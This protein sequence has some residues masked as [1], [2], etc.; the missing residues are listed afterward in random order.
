[1]TI[2][3]IGVGVAGVAAAAISA[4]SAGSAASGAADAQ[5]AAAAAGIAEQR[6]QFDAIQKLMQ[7]YVD[8]GTGALTGQQDLLGL[9]GNAA[10][11]KGINAIKTGSLYNELNQQGQTAILQNASATGGLRGGNTQGAL[12]QFSP[13][14][15]Q[16][17]INQQYQN[18][19]GL[20]TMGENAA[21]GVGAAGQNTGNQI[22]ALLQQQGAAQAGGILGQAKATQQFMG[23]AMKGIGMI[24]GAF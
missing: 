2:A 11:Q 17:L 4:G 1:M 16:T 10:Q 7:P 15:L 6:R 8:S 3:A 20:S 18:L 9:N 12:A 22:S 24:A 21:A 14:L 13:Q 23:S 19:G 5:S